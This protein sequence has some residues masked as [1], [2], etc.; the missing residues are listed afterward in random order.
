MAYISATATEPAFY[1]TSE[2]TMT[3][4]EFFSK[5]G[6]TDATAKCL[7]KNRTRTFQSGD[8]SVPEGRVHRGQC[9]PCFGDRDLQDVGRDDTERDTLHYCKCADSEHIREWDD[10][11]SLRVS[12][13][14]YHDANKVYPRPS[15]L[16]WRGHSLH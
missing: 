7:E 13:A 4:S 12:K 2:P 9:V 5:W 16:M 15:Y 3:R 14:C 10:V 6:Y 11:C 1:K 8:K